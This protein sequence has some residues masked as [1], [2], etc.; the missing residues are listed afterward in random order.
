MTSTCKQWV[1][2]NEPNHLNDLIIQKQISETLHSAVFW[3][4]SVCG[5][6]EQKQKIWYLNLLILTYYLS[7]CI[8]LVLHL[9]IAYFKKKKHNSSCDINYMK[10]Y[11]CPRILNFGII[12]SA[13]NPQD[14]I[15]LL[16]PTMN[17]WTDIYGTPRNP[18]RSC[19]DELKADLCERLQRSDGVPAAVFS[20]I[21]IVPRLQQRLPALEASVLIRH[22]P[23]RWQRM[24]SWTLSVFNQST[25]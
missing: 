8:K 24:L 3:V 18:H 10:L 20:P 17:I 4:N 22:P 16:N 2:S 9:I 7:Y 13:F 25:E 14:V 12:L 5:E 15:C 19:G 21:R 6:I 23:V 1:A 11:F